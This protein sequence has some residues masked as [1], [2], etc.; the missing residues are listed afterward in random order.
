MPFDS[1]RLAVSKKSGKF[2]YRIS[3]GSMEES[4]LF[5]GT[6]TMEYGLICTSIGVELSSK[7]SIQENHDEKFLYDNIAEIHWLPP[8]CEP[9]KW[10]MPNEI[11]N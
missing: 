4:T 9:G 5:G 11:G 1:D 6:K 10:A 2:Y 7:I 8:H 3:D